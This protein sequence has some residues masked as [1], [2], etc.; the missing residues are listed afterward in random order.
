M[1]AFEGA[2]LLERKDWVRCPK[3]SEDKVHC[4]IWIGPGYLFFSIKHTL[5]APS[6]DRV[7]QKADR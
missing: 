4:P 2:C 6:T 1:W 5:C 3:K 7:H